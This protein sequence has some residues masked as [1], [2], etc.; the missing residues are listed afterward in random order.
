VQCT[1]EEIDDIKNSISKEERTDFIN[2]NNV[3]CLIRDY[4]TV[5]QLDKMLNE[6]KYENETTT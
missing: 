5:A 4:K 6:L 1:T 3:T 2:K